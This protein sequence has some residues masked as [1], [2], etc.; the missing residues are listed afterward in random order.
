MPAAAH[1]EGRRR[2]L[3][4][5]SAAVHLSAMLLACGLSVAA[6]DANLT[7]AQAAWVHQVRSEF[8]ADSFNVSSRLCDYT[9]ICLLILPDC[10]NRFACCVRQVAR[11]EDPEVGSWLP[12]SA[13]QVAE[14]D[15]AAERW[16]KNYL[17]HHV[18]YNASVEV[19]YTDRTRTTPVGYGD[20][21]DSALWTGSFLAAAVHR[22]NLTAEPEVLER[23]KATVGVYENLTRVSGKVG[24]MGRFM[25][26]T[27]DP[28]YQRDYNGSGC[29]HGS[30]AERS[31]NQCWSFVGSPPFEDYTYEDHVSRD[32]YVGAALGLGTTF[33]LVGD[34][35]TRE[36]AVRN[37]ILSG[38]FGSLHLARCRQCEHAVL[39]RSRPLS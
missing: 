20:A 7:Q 38:V 6:G 25:G 8:S 29:A 9:A 11:G 36:R 23:I 27:E 1:G 35:P 14:V 2:D 12:M 30:N 37:K 39:A 17:D 13:D 10:V 26:L 22:Y 28:L 15:G 16:W 19:T 33:A 5:T 32:A 4:M 18:A 34:E 31:K 21:G 3:N 24:F